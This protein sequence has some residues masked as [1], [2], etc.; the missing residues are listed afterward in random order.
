[1]VRPH[2]GLAFL[3]APQG[4]RGS[5]ENVADLR[6]R[7]SENVLRIV[8][9]SP[10]MFDMTVM[11]TSGVIATPPEVPVGKI[12]PRT[13]VA[14]IT[15]AVSMGTPFVVPPTLGIE[16]PAMQLHDFLTYRTSESCQSFSLLSLS[17]SSSALTLPRNS[18]RF[19]SSS[20]SLDRFQPLRGNTSPPAGEALLPPPAD[21]CVVSGLD[22]PNTAMRCDCFRGQNPL[23]LYLHMRRSGLYCRPNPPVLPTG[24]V[25]RISTTLPE[26][27]STS[28][29]PVTPGE[30]GS[31]Q[32][33]LPSVQYKFSESGDLL[34]TGGNPAYGLMP[35]P[36]QARVVA[37]CLESL[38]LQFR[39]AVHVRTMST[40]PEGLV[41]LGV[42]V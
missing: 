38:R 18:A 9:T 2:S 33:G 36:I 8:S 22:D 7:K 13:T 34:C 20:F 40:V 35:L 42:I 28:A 27:S 11:R 1:M 24:S 10:L 16:L 19:S 41:Y 6:E 15:H 12:L 4:Q 3:T 29:T 39:R 32:S 5:S 23:V 14:N 30:D 26:G 21:D 37:G 17:A 31:V 25:F